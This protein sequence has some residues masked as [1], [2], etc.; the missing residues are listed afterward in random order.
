MS[1]IWS[2][3][4]CLTQ[5]QTQEINKSNIYIALFKNKNATWQQKQWLKTC[6]KGTMHT[7]EH[8]WQHR[9][10]RILSY[11]AF[12]LLLCAVYR[13][14]VLIIL[15]SWIKM[16]PVHQSESSIVCRVV[17]LCIFMHSVAA[18]WKQHIEGA[19]TQSR[20]SAPLLRVLQNNAN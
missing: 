2:K 12:I 16:Q 7:F 6:L 5:Q 3:Y 9:T 13:Q 4:T 18:A 20:L 11:K 17:Q 8:I 15:S 1:C 14:P 19:H 10:V